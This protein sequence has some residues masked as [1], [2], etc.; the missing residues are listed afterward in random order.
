MTVID[1]VKDAK[2]SAIC[3]NTKSKGIYEML[4]LLPTLGPNV[5]GWISLSSDAQINKDAL[6]TP[7]SNIDGAKIVGAY[8]LYGR[9]PEI[10]A[11]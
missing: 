3:E 9:N 6:I 7:C 5:A 10:F 11:A 8:S 4:N 1:A 2:F